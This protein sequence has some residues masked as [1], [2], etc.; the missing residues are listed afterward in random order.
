MARAEWPT[1]HEGLP[2]QSCARLLTRWQPPSRFA[3]S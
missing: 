1:R 3:R 2:E